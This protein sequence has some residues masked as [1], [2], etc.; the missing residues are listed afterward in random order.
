M[1]IYDLN[2]A[3]SG[4]YLAL[5]EALG[6][7][8]PPEWMVSPGREW[9]LF[10]FAC[11]AAPQSPSTRQAL[12]LLENLSAES[13]SRLRERAQAVFAPQ[14]RPR[15]WMY[16]SMYFSGRVLGPEMFAVEKWYRRFGV[17]PAGAELPDHASVELAFLSFLVE[18][19]AGS[20]A[21]ETR[22]LQQHAGRWLP[23]LGKALA[24]TQ[25]VVY[26]PLGLFLSTFI[27]QITWPERSLPAR[28]CQPIMASQQ[29]CKLCGFCI[30]RC[31]ERAIT[32]LEDARETWLVF[33]PRLC[34]G[35]GRCVRACIFGAIGMQPSAVMEDQSG[36]SGP[37][38]RVILKK[39]A[40]AV[41]RSCG[42]PM[43]S[44]DELN[45]VAE[46]LGSPL[47][48]MDCQECRTGL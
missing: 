4:L 40:R 7:G 2:T 48:L 42:Q 24:Q 12:G 32:L 23:Q 27:S 18:K 39:S 26:A 34:T 36:S 29:D 37:A 11:Q 8:E 45:Y 6:P 19:H 9:P 28:A 25:D 47:W 43:T 35:C 31:S 3:R 30:Q 15:F 13:P 1:G 46:V 14:G 33:D 20:P 44:M 17:E 38:A 21:L 22:F 10:E 16:E 41:C 5:A